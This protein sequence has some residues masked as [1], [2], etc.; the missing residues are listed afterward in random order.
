MQIALCKSTVYCARERNEFRS[1][2]FE[3]MVLK[4]TDYAVMG[5]LTVLMKG[6]LFIKESGPSRRLADRALPPAL[7]LLYYRSPEPNR[8]TFRY[9]KGSYRSLR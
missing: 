8:P 7:I 2:R 4:R 3:Y 9:L 6:V 5:K 1:N